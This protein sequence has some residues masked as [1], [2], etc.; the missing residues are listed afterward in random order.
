MTSRA[1]AATTAN[2]SSNS[3]NNDNSDVVV[4]AADVDD[5]PISALPILQRAF[6][7]TAEEEVSSYQVQG[8]PIVQSNAVGYKLAVRIV[9]PSSSSA[10]EITKKDGT[11]ASTSTRKTVDVFLKRVVANDYVDAK[12]DWT[13]LRRTLLYARNEARFY[14]TFLPLL[15]KRGGFD[16]G[17]VPVPYLAE[18][19]LEPWIRET[20][21]AAQQPSSIAGTTSCVDIK[22]QLSSDP[23]G[24]KI[25]GA[26]V[27]ECISDLTHYQDS[28]LSKRESMRCLEGVAHLHASAWQDVELLQ[29]AERE[30][31]KAS[32]HLQM[33]NPK[34]L[35]GIVDSW[36]KFC[37]AFRRP[38]EEAGL[39]TQ[40]R[41][42]KL[43]DRI[44]RL[45]QY[46]SRQVSP[47]PTDDYATII[48]GDYKSMN[49]FLPKQ[50]QQQQDGGASSPSSSDEKKE[51]VKLVDFASS[52]IGFGMSDLA[53]HIRHAVLPED[54]DGTDDD[55]GDGEREIVYH[56]WR[57]LSL[58]IR[59][60]EYPWDV[61]WRHYKLAV[62]DYFRFFLGR[63]WKSA[64]PETM[65]KKADNKNVNLIN[66]SVPAA[67]AFLK[68]VDAFLAEIEQEYEPQRQ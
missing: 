48:H 62:V 16:A 66:R 65:L 64:T 10:D 31:S 59:P 24:E 46:V 3:D 28:P 18:Y 35:T 12:K 38:M 53:M 50:Q 5:D 30:L 39:W 4:V 41:V 68:K 61:A 9:T 17:C 56:Y 14:K 20:E 43:G 7:S 34:E 36:T 32:F 6:P 58:L 57:Y 11:G 27:L 42:L 47:T 52:G 63:M 33:R 37:E 2:S 13:D 8:A 21:I 15:Q 54:L 49:A 22:R 45:A 44:E 51:K 29:Q 67:M 23:D 19:R 26:V 1:T 60:A 40:P 25:G 55:N